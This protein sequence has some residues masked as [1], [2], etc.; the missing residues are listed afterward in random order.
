MRII[1]KEISYI[2]ESSVTLRARHFKCS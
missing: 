2:Y 1:Q